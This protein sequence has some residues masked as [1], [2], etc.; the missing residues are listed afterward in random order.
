MES[1]LIK[2][3]FYKFEY[4]I[5]NIVRSN[6]VNMKRKEYENFADHDEV[7]LPHEDNI[8][9][10]VEEPNEGRILLRGLLVNVLQPLPSSFDLV[11]DYTRYKMSQQQHTIP[12]LIIDPYGIGI[13]NPQYTIAPASPP[14][15]SQLG[16][17]KFWQARYDHS[18]GKCICSLIQYFIMNAHSGSYIPDKSSEYYST[19]DWI[20]LNTYANVLI[21]GYT[22]QYDSVTGKLCKQVIKTSPVILY[23]VNQYGTGWALTLSG[24]YNLCESVDSKIIE[25]LCV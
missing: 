7:I 8:A 6:K 23:E 5:I 18:T 9:D 10:T 14:V 20:L 2:T 22:Y 1:E 13:E 17:T 4:F 25:E 19:N 12:R 24:L 15:L 21:C 11:S 16:I 3:F